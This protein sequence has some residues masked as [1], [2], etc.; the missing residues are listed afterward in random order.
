MVEICPLF[1]RKKERKSNKK[2][3][4]SSILNK[5]MGIDKLCHFNIGGWV[6]STNKGNED[7]KIEEKENLDNIQKSII[8]RIIHKT[9]TGRRETTT[10]FITIKS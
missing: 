1:A 5:K 10:K 8:R 3:T 7:K 9:S 2:K 4:Y 6:H